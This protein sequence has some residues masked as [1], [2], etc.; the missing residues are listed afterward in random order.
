[1]QRGGTAHPQALLG[2]VALDHAGD[3][4]LNL[5]APCSVRQRTDAGE[6]RRQDLLDVATHGHVAAPAHRRSLTGKHGA[7]SDDRL[8]Q[9]A[10]SQAERT[11][12]ESDDASGTR[13]RRLLGGLGAA[14]KEEP[15][16]RSPGVDSAANY[17]P[18]G[19]VA[20]ELP[21]AAWYPLPF[22]SDLGPPS[23]PVIGPAARSAPPGPSRH[24]IRLSSSQRATKSLAGS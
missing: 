18:D 9:A 1:M 15:S 8:G 20:S 19:W 22:A 13:V 12:T 16:W 24:P 11:H 5:G 10:L 17:V 21:F 7:Q 3:V 2:E 14:G 6:P 23:L 4:A